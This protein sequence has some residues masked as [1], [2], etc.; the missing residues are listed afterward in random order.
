MDNPINNQETQPMDVYFREHFSVLGIAMVI[1]AYLM[2]GWNVLP[3]DLKTIRKGTL[4]DEK[5]LMNIDA[6]GAP[7]I[8]AYLSQSRIT[9]Q[10]TLDDPI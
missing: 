5:V 6:R 1:S 3:R 7:A 2:A 4:F 8:L 10:V 9:P